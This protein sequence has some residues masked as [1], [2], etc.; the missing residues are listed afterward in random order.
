MLRDA[1]IEAGRL[2]P[3]SCKACFREEDIA[4]SDAGLSVVECRSKVLSSHLGRPNQGIIQQH[5]LG[6]YSSR[7]WNPPPTTTLT[8]KAFSLV[9]ILQYA[10][11]V[12][13]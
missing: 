8:R 13:P 2:I 3:L 9:H 1:G 7:L 5:A 10:V 11:A 6:T 12:L 4:A